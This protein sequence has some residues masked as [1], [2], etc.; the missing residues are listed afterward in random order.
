MTKIQITH[1]TK[2]GKLVF[3]ND[4]DN[5]LAYDYKCTKCGEPL[6]AKNKDKIKEHH[7]THAADYDCNG[8]SLKHYMA[9]AEI[10]ER[11]YLNIPTFQGKI[12]ERRL[13]NLVDFEKVQ[14]DK[15]INDSKYVA[16]IICTTSNG[17]QLVIE[18]VVTNELG[19]AKEQYLKYNKIPTLLID[20]NKWNHQ[21]ELLNTYMLKDNN[22]WVYNPKY[23]CESF[24]WSAK[25]DEVFKGMK[26][27]SGLRNHWKKY[28]EI[29]PK[30]IKAYKSHN[31]YHWKT[32]SDLPDDEDL[33][34]KVKI[35]KNQWVK[36]RSK[37]LT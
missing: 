2:N 4:V 15:Q 26:G 31:P 20:V 29:K 24:L 17:K 13:Y 21:I 28:D 22:R 23:S 19:K 37:S 34:M 12:M 30:P 18:I 1:A 16:D 27:F 33:P 32:D 11:K 6:V 3:I 35:S 7:F 10:N 9:K 36:T 8:E 25:K 14:V 5:S